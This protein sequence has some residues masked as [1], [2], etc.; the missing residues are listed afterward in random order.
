LPPRLPRHNQTAGPAARIERLILL[1]EPADLDRG[2]DHTH[3]PGL[4]QTIAGAAAAPAAGLVERLYADALPP[5]EVI[6][7]GGPRK[8]MLR[9]L[10]ESI[11]KRRTGRLTPAEG[12]QEPT[13]WSIS[14]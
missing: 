14:D 11:R 4:R 6:V 2:R 12:H 3:R 7:A 1:A 8:K 13:H 10:D 9:S 5:A